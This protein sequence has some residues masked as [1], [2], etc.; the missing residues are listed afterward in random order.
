MAGPAGEERA[1][2]PDVRP[3]TRETWVDF[4][5]LFSARGSPHYCWC[6]L[7]RDRRS[8]AMSK[9]EKREAMRS[10][11]AAGTPVGLLAYENGEP[12]GWCS[13]APRETFPKLERSKAMPAWAVTCFFVKRSQRGKG[14]TRLL[15]A[16][17]ADY[18]RD[19]G[20]LVVEGYPWDTSAGKSRFKGHSSAFR[21]AGFEQDG[22]RWHLDLRQGRR[23]TGDDGGS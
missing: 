9:D 5:L 10:T 14:V 18:A 13:V 20:A 19:N 7:Y 17:A 22:T 23:D 11:V 6:M 2:P 15:L 8:Q 21:G 12:V 3:V 16:A 4:E 1:A